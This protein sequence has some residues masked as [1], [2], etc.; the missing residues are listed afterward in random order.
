MNQDRGV[1]G[2]CGRARN[3]VNLQ[4]RFLEEAIKHTPRKGTVGTAALQREIDQDRIASRSVRSFGT[5][6][7]HPNYNSNVVALAP[8]HGSE[9]APRCD[10]A[11]PTFP[12]FSVVAFS[13]T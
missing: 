10:R 2:A 7:L 11:T 1:H 12:R 9:A 13:S 3:S 8:T 4:P 5:W 6:F